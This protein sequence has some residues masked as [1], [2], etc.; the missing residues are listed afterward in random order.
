MQHRPSRQK[1]FR[2]WMPVLFNTLEK[3]Q[4]KL[5]TMRLVSF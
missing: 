4:Y 5:I 1:I 3:L 2:P